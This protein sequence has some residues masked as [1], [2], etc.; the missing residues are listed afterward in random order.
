M[1]PSDEPYVSVVIPLFNKRE[2]VARAIDS[3]LA[4]SFTSFEV[5]VVN[6]GSTDGSGDVVR[7]YLDRVIYLEQE[8]SGAGAARNRAIGISRA[9]L[10]AFL[11]ADDSWLPRKLE[12]QTAFMRAQPD[13]MWCGVNC[14]FVS[15]VTT[16]IDRR[17]L[18]PPPSGDNPHWI[19]FTDWF[20]AE[21]HHRVTST[22]CVMVR[23]AVFD[24]AGLFATDIFAGQDTDFWIRT[25][26]RYPA[27]GYCP[28]PLVRVTTR[29]PGCL[30][31]SG[32]RKL[33]SMLGFMSRHAQ[34]VVQHPDPRPSFVDYTKRQM[35]N[36]LR[37][38]LSQGYPDIARKVVHTVPAAWLTSAWWGLWLL[39]L[40]PPSVVRIASA[41]RRH[42][43]VRLRGIRQRQR[44]RR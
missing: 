41:W 23:R 14:E 36:L 16:S 6:D 1:T 12:L 27:Y 9:P 7:R 25:A 3:V 40:L 43:L 2:Q 21:L 37:T 17:Y 32:R 20:A 22:P 15:G 34:R 11:D 18:G 31:L 35:L 4:Q 39:S 44:D 8:N 26:L 5:V 19:V 28:T 30:S 29:L 24:T 10:I 33:E 13:I 38:C 42:A